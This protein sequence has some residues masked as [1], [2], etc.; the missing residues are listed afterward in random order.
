MYVDHSSIF[1]ATC[2][3]LLSCGSACYFIPFWPSLAVT[4]REGETGG[5]DRLQVYS[6]ELGKFLLLL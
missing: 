2:F 1:S 4:G 5:R 3:L 6:E